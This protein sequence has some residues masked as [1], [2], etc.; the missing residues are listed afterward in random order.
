MQRDD[1]A[2]GG[3]RVL[4]SGDPRWAVLGDIVPPGKLTATKT[5][6]QRSMPAFADPYTPHR[7]K[8]TSYFKIG[9]SGEVD[10]VGGLDQSD[11]HIIQNA[12]YGGEYEDSSVKGVERLM[13]GLTR[14]M[15]TDAGLQC[16]LKNFCRVWAIP[17]DSVAMVNV[18][19]SSTIGQRDQ[20]V[21]KAKRKVSI[22][23]Q[24]IHQDGALRVG[25]YCV[26]RSN[27]HGIRNSLYDD[28][29]G[30]VTLLEPTI[31]QENQACVFHD[32]K[33]Y[34]YVSPPEIDFETGEGLDFERTIIL[35]HWP[36]DMFM[37]GNIRGS[38][39]A[40]YEDKLLA[41]DEHK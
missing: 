23:D 9:G 4:A 27:V 6:L 26:S 1:M 11:T 36:G 28:S 8:V 31:L 17:T 10:W 19:M 15:K 22:T 18:H 38:E 7:A 41:L 12:A 2:A 34:H 21:M 29:T 35:I 25:I 3:F 24:G 40:K 32:V 16:C 39:Y 33:L 37:G 30:Q 13:K 14:E 5:L 20:E